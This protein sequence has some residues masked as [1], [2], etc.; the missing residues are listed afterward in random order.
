MV[1][2]EVKQKVDNNIPQINLPIIPTATS[3]NTNHALEILEL[4]KSVTSNNMETLALVDAIDLTSYTSISLGD[5]I[6]LEDNDDWYQNRAFYE[7]SQ[8]LPDSGILNSYKYKH[9]NDNPEWY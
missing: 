7:T 6:E 1:K 5:A 9:I 2:K 3:E 8:V 4:V